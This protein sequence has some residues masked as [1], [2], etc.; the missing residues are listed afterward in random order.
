MPWSS[1]LLNG[2]KWPERSNTAHEGKHSIASFPFGASVY[3]RRA[4]LWEL[5]LALRNEKENNTP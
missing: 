2:L 5:K 3:T 1:N 4:E